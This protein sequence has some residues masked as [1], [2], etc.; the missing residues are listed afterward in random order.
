MSTNNTAIIIT[1]PYNDFLHSNGK[2]NNLLA[3]SIAEKDALRKD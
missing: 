3:E 2:L 1:D